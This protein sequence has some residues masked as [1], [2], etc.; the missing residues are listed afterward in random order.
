MG[1]RLKG[2]TGALTALAILAISIIGGYE[3]LRLYSYKDVVGVWT[4]CFGETEGI[5]PGMRFTREQCDRMF[6]DSGLTRHERALRRCLTSPDEVPM[7]TYVAML[8]LAY[9]IGEGGFCRSSVVRRWN[10]GDHYGAC[11]A[12]LMW[13]KAGGRVVQGLVNR[14]KSE[15]KLCI[16]GLSEPVTLPNPDDIA[17]A[18]RPV[19]R[20]G[21][22]GFW[23]EHLQQRL[24]MNLVDGQFGPGTDAVVRQFQKAHGLKVDGV[25]GFNTWTV[26]AA[27]GRDD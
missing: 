3:G 25:V 7:K 4:A 15:R 16:E 5:K 23:V 21:S 12:F 26:I 20:R 18:D 6:V 13:N 19:L 1:T 8:S 9:N 24:R 10:A 2:P 22:A 14:R 27:G 17:P 11:D